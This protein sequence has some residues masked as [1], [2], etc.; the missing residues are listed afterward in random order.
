MFSSLKWKEIIVTNIVTAI[1]SVLVTLSLSEKTELQYVVEKPVVAEFRGQ[2]VWKQTIGI[3]NSGDRLIEKVV[4]R[5][6]FTKSHVRGHEHDIVDAARPSVRQR[7]HDIQLS[8]EFLNPGERLRFSYF[9][10]KKNDENAFVVVRGK[11][12][13]GK[14]L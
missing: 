10:D 1:V 3:E 13:V 4:M 12:A 14:K 9:F 5:V 8:L 6:E 2:K 7:S 11:G